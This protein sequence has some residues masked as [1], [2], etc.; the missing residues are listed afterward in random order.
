MPATGVQPRSNASRGRA[1]RVECQHR[2]RSTARMPAAD[3]WRWPNATGSGERTAL[4]ECQPRAGSAGRMP[5]ARAQHSANASGGR[6]A[7][8][9]CQQR[10][11]TIVRMPGAAAQRYSNA[12]S[13]RS[14][15]SGGRALHFEC[16]QRAG[17]AGRMPARAAQCDTN[18]SNVDRQHSGYNSQWQAKRLL[19]AP[20]KAADQKHPVM[21]GHRMSKDRPLDA[22]HAAQHFAACGMT[23]S[24]CICLSALRIAQLIDAQVLRGEQLPCMRG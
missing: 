16:Q 21:R 17:S 5:A 23:D 12:A 20:K 8:R 11:S 18:A 9:K 3:A 15:A 10:N 19:L 6:T 1:A 24:R 2:A 4:F 22:V 13:W 14:D 7:Q